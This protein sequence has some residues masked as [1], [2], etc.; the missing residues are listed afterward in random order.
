MNSQ[1]VNSNEPDKN[2]SHQVSD[3]A[4]PNASISWPLLVLV[5]TVRL[6]NT[7]LIQSYF[8]P[9]E[10]WQTMEPAYCEAFV[11]D[12]PC[13]GFTW[14]WK[15]RPPLSAGNFLEQSMWGPART[16]LSILPTYYFF[17]FVKAL[18]F[19]SH[20]VVA[21]GPMILNSLIV[22]APVD[23]AVWYA[24]RWL[25]DPKDK[26]RKTVLPGWCLFCSLVSWFNGY[27]LVRTFANSQE[28]LILI[29]AVALM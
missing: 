20:W 18:G 29:L 2:R 27:S 5:F 28:T 24:A 21:R 4:A 17:L 9:D 1:T 15:R 23:I 16:F 22:A 25:P 10:F 13:A 6:L 3:V 26:T 11:H 7:S 14:E 8:D 12:R 19:D